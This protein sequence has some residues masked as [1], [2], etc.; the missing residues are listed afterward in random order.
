LIFSWISWAAVYF[1]IWWTTLFA[2]LPFGARSQFDDGVISPGTEP[3]APT[4]ARIG[5]LFLITTAAATV[6]FA[7]L[8]WI[9]R[10]DV[11][12]LDDIPFLPRFD[13]VG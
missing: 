1:V 13:R 9:L 8:F 6:V 10:Q 12:G 3:G 11:F 5:R 7:L 4:R 2:V